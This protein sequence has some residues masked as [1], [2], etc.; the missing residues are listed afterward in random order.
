MRLIRR[1]IHRLQASLIL[2]LASYCARQNLQ[3]LSTTKAQQESGHGRSSVNCGRCITATTAPPRLMMFSGCGAAP[4]QTRRTRIV[5]GECSVDGQRMAQA[6]PTKVGRRRAAPLVRLQYY[7]AT[8]RAKCRMS[9]SGHRLPMPMGNPA[10]PRLQR[11]KCSRK[12]QPH[13]LHLEP[14][15]PPFGRA[16]RVSTSP[17]SANAGRLNTTHPCQHRLSY[18]LLPTKILASCPFSAA[19]CPRR[20]AVLH[21][22]RQVASARSSTCSVIIVMSVGGSAQTA[23]V[24]TV[25]HR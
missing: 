1:A 4:F 8:K 23:Q 18:A 9:L 10:S 17:I 16:G 25:V 14:L 15:M 7:Q 12:I 6:P 24:S 5:T 19:T 20:R 3:P 13:L 11:A 2:Q 21:R 22:R